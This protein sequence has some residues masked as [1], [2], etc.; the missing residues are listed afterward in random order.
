MSMLQCTNFQTFINN[1]CLNKV[2]NPASNNLRLNLCKHMGCAT[3]LGGGYPS[4]LQ[5]KSIPA[6]AVA[7]WQ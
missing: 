2:G 5:Q 6:E 4:R 1:T 7:V 3:L